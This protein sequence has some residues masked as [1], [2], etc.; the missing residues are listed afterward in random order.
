MGS[1]ITPFISKS[2]QVNDTILEIFNKKL[3]LPKGALIKLHSKDEYSGSE[4]RMTK[5]PFRIRS[6]PDGDWGPYGL[7][8]PQP[9]A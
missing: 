5:K 8:F 6:G 1:T 2:V 7:W 4:A 9:S 3:G